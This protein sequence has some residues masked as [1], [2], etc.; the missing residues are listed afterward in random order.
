MMILL[1]LFLLQDVLPRD[2][3]AI[4]DFMYHGEVNVKQD[5]LNS[6]L[7]VAEKL[8]V[9]GLCQSDSGV[10]NS[11]GAKSLSSQQHHSEK[12]KSRPSDTSYSEP[13][14]KKSRVQESQDDDI[15]EIPQV[16]QE[17]SE[18]AGSS[19]LSSSRQTGG[20]EYQM[21]EAGAGYD[22]SMQSGDYG[23]EYYDDE[24]GYG[25]EGAMVDPSQAKGK[26]H[27]FT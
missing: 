11:S 3:A 14:T 9:R 20:E 21:T 25:V 8:R 13:N 1:F 2:L 7:A 26:N 23:E 12:P 24:M 15:E 18:A 6:F 16:K 27:S 10:N 4:L 22:D 19:R 17:M 5:H